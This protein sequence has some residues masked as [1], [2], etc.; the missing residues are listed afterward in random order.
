MSSQGF[1]EPTNDELWAQPPVA[2][3]Q[4]PAPTYPVATPNQ[5]VALPVMQVVAPPAVRGSSGV[6]RTQLA[7]AI[8]SLAL[9]I[10]LSA[11]GAGTIGVPGFVIA[12]VGIVLVNF[13]YGKYHR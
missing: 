5:Q 12:W 9:G 3:V 13:F 10:P 7:L 4:A 1:R 2:P 6:D 8:V 11:V